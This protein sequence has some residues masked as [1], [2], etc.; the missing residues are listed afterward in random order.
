MVQQLTGGLIL[1]L[2]D[3]F[4]VTSYYSYKAN[5]LYMWRREIEGGAR[6]WSLTST[7]VYNLL[8][9]IRI[10]HLVYQFLNE[11]CFTEE[12]V[13]AVLVEGDQL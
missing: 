4:G 9:E 6:G 3:K 5:T 2:I 8:N 12:M 1:K 10:Y 13:E 11:E 7:D